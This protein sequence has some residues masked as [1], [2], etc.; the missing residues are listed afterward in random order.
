M[1]TNDSGIRNDVRLPRLRGRAW[2]ST[3][4]RLP[5]VFVSEAQG[6]E[7][8][9]AEPEAGLCESAED[10]EM[11]SINADFSFRNRKGR[12][13]VAFRH[14]AKGNPAYVR[15]THRG[16]VFCWDNAGGRWKPCRTHCL[17]LIR[18]FEKREPATNQGKKRAR[19]TK[20]KLRV[21]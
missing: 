20:P 10:R 4:G 16:D 12:F 11:K 13:D 21:V 8:R 15:V 2:V 9:P 7:R 6:G 18:M 17:E 3:R 1:A 14:D 19:K 5:A